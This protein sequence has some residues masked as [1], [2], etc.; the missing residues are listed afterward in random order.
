MQAGLLNEEISIFFPTITKDEYGSDIETFQ[1]Y[2]KTRSQVKY[3]SGNRDITN[4]EIVYNYS[5]TFIVRKYVQIMENMQ[6][7]FGGKKYRI[8]S[9]EE[10]KHL[11]CKNV[12]TQLIIE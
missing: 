3:S 12:I 2:T 1:Y 9:I 4:N 6:I 7:H 5:V 11:Q 8:L 10:N